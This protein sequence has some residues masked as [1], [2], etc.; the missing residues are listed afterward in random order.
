MRISTL[1]AAVGLML[2]ATALSG[3]SEEKGAVAAPMSMPKAQVGVVVIKPSKV[4]VLSD[5]TGR[6]SASMTAEVRP[7]IGGIVLEK[8]FAEGG[9]IRAG[10]PLYRIDPKSYEAS[11]AAAKA[12]L[13][14]A[15][16]ELPAAAAKLERL[17]SLKASNAASAQ[18]LEDAVASE[19]KA[20]ADVAAAKAQLA[21][22]ELD[23]GRTVVSAPIS[24]VVGRSALTQGALVSA[25]Q[26]EALTT[27]RQIDP[28]NVDVAQTSTA[29]LKLRKAIAEG[30]IAPEQ[31]AVKVKLKLEDGS[32][33]GQE[34]RLEFSE[35]DVDPSTGT[36]RVRA[37]FPNPDRTLLP[38]M[39]VRAV[40]EEGVAESGIVVPQRAV[41]RNVKG[42]AVV[43]V[44]SG[45]KVEERVV[46]VDGNSGND[47]IVAS[48]LAAGDQVVVEGSAKAKPGQ[49][50][51]A[52]E[53]SVDPSTGL[54]SDAKAEGE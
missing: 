32:L 37:S 45:G 25:N 46:G 36:F 54:A 49:E 16:A 9:A 19:A 40:V 27:I 3:C 44:V 20:R 29:F 23:L 24:G 11:R 30:R 43:L 41:S 47:W 26:A 8:L 18:D 14:R 2:A 31:G 10:E 52:V 7:Q 22:A 4:Q 15:E 5:M 35:T 17:R 6:T 48:G 21:S 33:Y 28:I 1:A 12:S 50:V 13:E 39:F 42:E 53:V 38:G 34:G 51:N